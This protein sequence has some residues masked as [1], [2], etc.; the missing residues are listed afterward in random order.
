M[1]LSK[2]IRPRMIV[3]YRTFDGK[4]ISSIRIS[5]TS[6]IHAKEKL[7]IGEDVFI[8]HYNFI[9]ASNGIDIGKFCQIT[10]YVSITSHSSHISIRLY[11]NQ[12]RKHSDLI[13][14][15]KGKI[16]IGAYTFI[17]PHTVIMPGTKIGKA[18]LVS[19]YSYL[20]GDYPDYSIIKG[21][22][23]KVVGSTKEIDKSYIEE[24]PELK[25]F[26][27]SIEE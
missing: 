9:E 10:N 3:G 1:R 8:G 17:G 23:A 4:F 25:D 13:A 11:A 15:Q 7:K 6:F 19:A 16:S 5:N 22:P 18:C 2:W 12:Y 21:N 27:K 24:N 14:Y 26:Y 20:E